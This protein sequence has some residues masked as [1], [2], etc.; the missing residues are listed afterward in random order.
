M[1]D[2][3]W[4]CSM[5][6][7]QR[8]LSELFSHFLIRNCGNVTVK[9]LKIGNMQ[10]QIYSCWYKLCQLWCIFASEMLLIAHENNRASS[11]YA[12]IMWN[13]KSIKCDNTVGDSK[14]LTYLDVCCV[15]ISETWRCKINVIN[16]KFM[17]FFRKVFWFSIYSISMISDNA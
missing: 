2:S 7:D 4:T 9:E 11:H 17:L 1:L 14:V 12:C 8:M 15:C 5:C 3:Y 6:S 10:C 16:Y 13:V